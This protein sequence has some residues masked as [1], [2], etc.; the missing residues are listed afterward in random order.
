MDFSTGQHP[1]ND[2]LPGPQWRLTRRC[3]LTPEQLLLSYAVLVAFSAVIALVFGW[4][5]YWVVP[6]H[7]LLQ[8]VIAG[9]MYFYYMLHAADGEQITFSPDGDLDIEVVRGLKV[10]HYRMNLAWARLERGGARQERLWLCCSPLRV[11]V[12]TRLAARDRRRVER[13]LKQA[14]A[15]R[16]SGAICATS[17]PGRQEVLLNQ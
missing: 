3:A 17:Q 1:D 7:C 13:E 16:Q 6:L 14:L 5:G 9:A 15:D 11:E 10:R 12:A 8:L 2:P 4:H